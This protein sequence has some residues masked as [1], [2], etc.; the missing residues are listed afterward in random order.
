MAQ[1]KGTGRKS[2]EGR[3]SDGEQSGPGS[4]NVKAHSD[5]QGGQPQCR[6][7][8]YP[9]LVERRLSMIERRNFCHACGGAF[10]SSTP[11]RCSANFRFAT[12]SGSRGANAAPARNRGWPIPICLRGNGRC[13]GC[14]T[15]APSSARSSRKSPPPR[16]IFPASYN[17][18]ADLKSSLGPANAAR[19]PTSQMTAPIL[20]LFRFQ[21]IN[22]SFHIVPGRLDAHT[23]ASA[24]E[25]G[26][27]ARFEACLWLDRP[28]R[29]LRHAAQ[30]VRQ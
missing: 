15:H 2:H 25:P 3:R 20:K 1:R 30:A 5:R 12:I 18:L 16:Q 22:Q 19:R 23:R 17:W 6:Q 14:S 29:H 27:V 8:V 7:L 13:P 9:P 21:F 10:T 26:G 24:G 4:G 28:A 11:N